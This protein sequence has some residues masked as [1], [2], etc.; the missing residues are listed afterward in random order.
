MILRLPHQISLDKKMM[1]YL[2]RQ[3]RMNK[4]I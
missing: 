2:N 1:Q 3:N 4:K